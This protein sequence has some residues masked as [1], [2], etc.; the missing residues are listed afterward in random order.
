M[1]RGRVELDELDVGARHA[2]PQGHGEAVPRRL[3]RV[4]GRGEELTRAAGRQ[5]HVVRA[6]LVDRTVVGQ[7]DHAHA[8]AV[9]HEEV[10][11]EPALPARHGRRPHPV[12]QRPLDLGACGGAAGVDDAGLRVAAFA[13]ELQP[14][15]VVAVEDRPHGDELVDAARALVHQGSHGLDVA[16]P[17][18]RGEGV[19]EVQ[20]GRVGVGR[21]HGGDAALRPAGRRLRELGLREHADPQ[22]QLVGGA[23]GGRQA[24]HPAAQDEQVELVGS[25]PGHGSSSCASAAEAATSARPPIGCTPPGSTRSRQ[26]AGT[27]S[28][29]TSSSGASTKARS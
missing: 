18:P 2:G 28:G 25:Q 8:R 24:G 22:A 26:P 16:Q 9:L 14:P 10:E 15:V 5:Q 1:Q 20:V 12:D 21:E 19:G 7:R 23:D 17:G 29:A 13:S 27:R 11:R 6:D 4:G 3:E